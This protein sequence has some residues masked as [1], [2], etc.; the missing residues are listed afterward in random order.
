MIGIENYETVLKARIMNMDESVIEIEEHVNELLHEINENNL[1]IDKEQKLYVVVALRNIL[2]ELIDNVNRH[3][4]DNEKKYYAIYIRMRYANDT[5][6]KEGNRNNEY[7]GRNRTK[8]IEVYVH[9]AIEIYFQDIGKGI[10]KSQAEKDRKYDKRP[11]REIVKVIFFR[12]DFEERIDNTSI[13]GLAFLRKI[14]QEK[15]NY[16]SVYN[17]FEGTGAFGVK[18]RQMNTNNICLSDLIKDASNGIEGQIYNFT[19]FDRHNIVGDT[20]EN[21]ED[22]LNIYQERYKK[23]ENPVIDMRKVNPSF[24]KIKNENCVLLFMPEYLTK[25]IILGKLKQALKL[26]DKAE[27]II[28]SDVKIRRKDDETVVRNT[29]SYVSEKE[30]YKILH[31]YAYSSVLCGHLHFEKRHDLLSIN[32]NAI[33]YDESTKL[34][35]YVNNVIRYS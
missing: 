4:Y 28:I 13:N 26:L 15:N 32:L 27:N 21:Y 3:A 10:V 14:L 22:L 34:K 24:I 5:T 9:T 8:P 17:Q 12:E 25:S 7:G 16:F 11:L 35:E 1:N 20:E 6:K 29:N 33:M 31:Q 30:M 23:I 19:L 2:Q 18:D